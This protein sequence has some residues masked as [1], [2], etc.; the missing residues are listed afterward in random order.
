M[1]LRGSSS[2]LASS[3]RVSNMPP[4]P[5]I[6]RERKCGVSDLCAWIDKFEKSSSSSYFLGASSSS[7][8]IFMEVRPKAGEGAKAE[9]P[10]TKAR[11]AIENFIVVCERLAIGIVRWDGV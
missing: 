11:R 5:L 1:D 3:S 10:A 8:N 4:A 2:T 6:V 7:A 9:A